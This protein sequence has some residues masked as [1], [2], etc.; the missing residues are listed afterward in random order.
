MIKMKRISVLVISFILTNFCVYPGLIH[1]QEVKTIKLLAPQIES[2]KT[3]MQALKQRQTL[4]EFSPKELPLQVISDLLWAANGINRPDSGHHTAPTAM[5]LQEIDIYVA[6]ADGLYIFNAKANALELI[7]QQ[8]LRALAGSQEFVKDAPVNLIFVADLSKM[9]KM[10]AED[11]NFYS[12]TDTGFISQNVYLYCASAGLA[13]VVRGWIDKPALS[14]AM[15]LR[16]DQ[17]IT[18]A[19]TVGYPKN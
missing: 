7:A 4:R 5:N 1:A 12:G 16:P 18:L 14:K 9:N 15:K 13:T 6:K 2:G 17:R 10:P 19:Q 8:D 3:L 11:A